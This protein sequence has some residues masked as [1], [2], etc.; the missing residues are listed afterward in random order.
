MTQAHPRL[1]C[2]RLCAYAGT[3]SL[4]NGP[5]PTGDLVHELTDNTICKVSPIAN[6]NEKTAS[7]MALR[8]QAA[9]HPG[10]LSLGR[11]PGSVKPR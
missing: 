5:V 3:L 4:A 11:L 10:R 6:G 8:W 9:G 2:I 7:Q 1:S